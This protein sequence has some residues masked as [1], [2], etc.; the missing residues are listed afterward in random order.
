MR[1]T[2]EF[3]SSTEKRRFEA[4]RRD[5]CVRCAYKTSQSMLEV[6]LLFANAHTEKKNGV[7]ITLHLCHFG[8]QDSDSA[9]WITKK[10]IPKFINSLIYMFRK[11]QRLY[12]LFVFNYK[13]CILNQQSMFGIQNSCACEQTSRKLDN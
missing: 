3:A 6:F 1:G 2:R 5:V 13:S 7:Y 10:L 11:I 8:L 9:H 12:V 4:L